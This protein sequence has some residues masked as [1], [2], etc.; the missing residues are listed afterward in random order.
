MLVST[1]MLLGN[2]SEPC[3]RLLQRLK[4]VVAKDTVEKW[5][6]QHT[7]ELK[8]TETVL[9]FVFDNCNFYLNTT[10]KTNNAALEFV[11]ACWESFVNRPITQPLKYLYKGTVCRVQK[12]DFTILKPV[13]DRKTLLYDDVEAVIMEFWE[14]F[15]QFTNRVFAF[16]ARDP[17]HPF[18]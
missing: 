6:K 3:W 4:I 7:K 14:K 13:I 5:V 2:I 9:W 11:I 15:M 18:P 16:L 1:Y 12:C 17:V 8:S 10:K